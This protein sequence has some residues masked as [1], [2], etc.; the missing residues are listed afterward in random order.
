MLFL[1]YLAGIVDAIKAIFI[2]LFF[3]LSALLVII[4]NIKFKCAKFYYLLIIILSIGLLTPTSNSIYLIIGAST[5]KQFMN[6]TEGN[7]VNKILNLSLDKI[8]NN[9]QESNN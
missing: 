8:I 6:T 5:T 3:M 4:N 1:I 7:K 9:L 2:A